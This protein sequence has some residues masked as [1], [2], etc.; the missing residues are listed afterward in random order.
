MAGTAVTGDELRT[1]LEKHLEGEDAEIRVV[2]PAFAKD[3]L[4]QYT[5]DVDEGLAAAQERLDTTIEDLRS[6]GLQVSGTVG[7]SE[8]DR[9]IEDVLE[10]FPAD[11]IL[12]VTHPDED[13][14]W[15]EDEAFERS[16][17]YFE[18]SVTRLV[19]GGDDDD[20]HVQDV[21]EAPAGRDDRPEDEPQ[22]PNFP[23]LSVRDLAAI[24]V[25]IVGTAVVILLASSCDL[26]AGRDDV[27]VDISECGVRV[28]IAW[29]ITMMNAAH[30]V[31][32]MFFQTVR[33]R[34]FWRKFFTVVTYVATPIAVIASL[35]LA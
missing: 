4:H 30:I 9:A 15:L 34:G 6:H 14:R 24:A 18:Q 21:Q 23:P 2:A 12:L 33:Y 35:L 16:S 11:E 26:P 29:A 31:G 20:P 1:E 8:P 28:I 10:A 3:R 17:A 19:V 5:G 32:L 13:A 7:D 27:G 25:A 22:P